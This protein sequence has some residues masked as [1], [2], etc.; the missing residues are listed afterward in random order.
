M[1]KTESIG[2]HGVASYYPTPRGLTE[3]MMQKI[4]VYA[5]DVILEPSAG[6][7]D[8]SGVIREMFP[9]NELLVIERDPM[10]SKSLKDKGFIKIASD[11]LAWNG[12]VNVIFGNPPFS[13]GYQDI[14]HTYHAWRSLK[15][16]GR[17]CFIVHYKSAHPGFDREG[18]KAVEFKRWLS[19]NGIN[20]VPV[21]GAFETARKTSKTAISLIWGTK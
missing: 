17:L 6:E 10:L 15:K 21:F 9:T 19:E 2:L 16:G 3:V 20:S 13:N 14:D 8:M 4:P 12:K 5:G 18:H 1:N 7:G 11:F